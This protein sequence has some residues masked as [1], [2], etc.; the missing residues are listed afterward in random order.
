MYS[1][2]ITFNKEA[3]EKLKKDRENYRRH[4]SERETAERHEYAKLCFNYP[5]NSSPKGGK[6]WT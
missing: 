6:F 5:Y 2:G 4:E 3:L 1:S